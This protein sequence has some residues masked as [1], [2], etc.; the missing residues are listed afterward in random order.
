M[1]Y[2][3]ISHQKQALTFMLR[4]ERGWALH[5]VDQSDAWKADSL[6]GGRK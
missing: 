2:Y 4:R 6:A 5:N 3:G 1:T